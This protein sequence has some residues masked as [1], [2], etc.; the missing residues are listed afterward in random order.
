MF[1]RFFNKKNTTPDTASTSTPSTTTGSSTSSTT[2]NNESPSQAPP[3]TSVSASASPSPSTSPPPTTSTTVSPSLTPTPTTSHPLS[4]SGSSVS[5]THTSPYFSSSSTTGL[6][7]GSSS[8]YASGSMYTGVQIVAAPPPPPPSTP[9][10]SSSSVPSSLSSPSFT[11]HWARGHHN[12]DHHDAA[13]VA[14]P[15]PGVVDHVGV[16]PVPLLV[17]CGG[18]RCEPPGVWGLGD[19]PAAAAAAEERVRAT[20][21]WVAGG[22]ASCE[23]VPPFWEIRTTKEGRKYYVDHTS[24]ATHWRVPWMPPDWEMWVDRGRNLPFYVNTRTKTPQWNPPVPTGWRLQFNPQ[25]I[26]F[27]LDDDSNVHNFHPL[28]PAAPPTPEKPSTSNAEASSSSSSG[29]TVDASADI[30]TSCKICLDR[31]VNVVLLRCG[32]LCVCSVCAA[33]LRDCPICRQ[34]IQEVVKVF[35]A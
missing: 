30:E 27:Y 15:A 10:S 34:R 21:I 6:G 8:G 13:H 4:S 32:H 11:P 5:S 25:G 1:S 23:Y 33:V 35:R 2:T 9:T 28:N 20:A 14:P 16:L 19:Q 17:R 31:P 3:V 26:P 12:A 24:K 7:G 29:D 18:A 22:G